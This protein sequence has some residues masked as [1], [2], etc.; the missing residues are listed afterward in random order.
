VKVHF[1]N[2]S[3]I[4]ELLDY[5][6]DIKVTTANKRPRAGMCSRQ[7]QVNFTSGLRFCFWFEERQMSR[8]MTGSRWN[9]STS[10]TDLQLGWPISRGRRRRSAR[11]SWRYKS[12]T[13]HRETSATDCVK[14]AA[15]DAL[16]VLNGAAWRRCGFC[17]ATNWHRRRCRLLLWQQCLRLFTFTRDEQISLCSPHLSFQSLENANYFT[18]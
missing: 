8:I 10:H 6:M 18:N 16:Q 5:Q 3:V 4:F 1:Q 12:A 9:N 17:V 14:S 11:R 7:T 15:S 2:I 13:K